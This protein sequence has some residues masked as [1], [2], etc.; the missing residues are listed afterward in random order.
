MDVLMEM[1]KAKNNTWHRSQLYPELVYWSHGK[2][3]LTSYPV[4]YSKWDLVN[5]ANIKL[6][7]RGLRK[8]T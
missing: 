2:G 8:I 1:Y 6:F 7:G 5:Q 4:I 3:E